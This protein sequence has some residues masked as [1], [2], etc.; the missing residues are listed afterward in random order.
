MKDIENRQ[1]IE[2]LMASFYSVAMKDETIGH[3]FTE[4]VPLNLE[5]HIPL[6]SDFWETVIFDKAVYRGNVFGVHEHI[7]TLFAFEDKHFERWVA[8][9][10]Q[11][12]NESFVGSNAEKI[13]QR[14]ESIATVM[15]IKLVHSG[16]ELKK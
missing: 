10:K 8:L 9:F 1:D 5:K 11:T 3:F 2:A 15:R 6:I 12:V 16:I 4:V 13:K 14:G 7:H